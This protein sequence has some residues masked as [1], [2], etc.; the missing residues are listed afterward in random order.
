[1]KKR[2]L[3]F[4]LIIFS[5]SLMAQVN[6]SIFDQL[7]EN[8]WYLPT[9]DKSASLYVTNIGV[10]D[11][12]VTLHGGPG[13]DF[14]YLVD[15][16]KGNSEGNTFVLFDQRGS[17]LSPVH[18]SLVSHLSIDLLVD[19]L[20]NLRKALHQEK[21]TLF[22]H[23]FGTLL[24]ISYYLKYPQHVKGIILSASMPPFINEEQPFN[25]FLKEIRKRLQ[26]LRNRPEVKAEL[27]K[28][29]VGNGSLLSPKQKSDKFK[30]Q[31]LA[32]FNMMNIAN[33]RKFKGGQVYYNRLVDDA[34]GESIPAK[35]DIRPLLEKYATPITVIQGDHDY[36]DPAASTWATVCSKFNF[37]KV[38][39]IK[40]ASHN[41][42]LDDQS[43]FDRAMRHA[44]DRLTK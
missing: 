36:I 30:I 22:G 4:V 13:N 40:N 21:M 42:W 39:T 33:W 8:T 6:S 2:L 20:E 14:N 16:V 12:I 32:S 9:A 23:S 44:I 35:Y 34:I 11:T 27:A 31:G 24:A 10:G 3:F 18:D 5:S 37:V 17:L 25:Q 43:N 41:S 26:A 19:D 7:M 38:V 28:I 15:A 1:M 29:G